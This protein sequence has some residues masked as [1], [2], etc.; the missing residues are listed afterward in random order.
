VVILR[1]NLGF[2]RN[3]AAKYYFL[4]NLIFKNL[5]RR[6]PKNDQ[7]DVALLQGECACKCDWLLLYCISIL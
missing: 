7:F 3:E 6:N 1:R 2:F 4:L 5:W